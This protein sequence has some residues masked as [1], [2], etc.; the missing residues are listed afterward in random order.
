MERHLLKAEEIDTF[1]KEQPEW[2]FS[3][4]SLTRTYQFPDFVSAFAFMSAVATHC[5]C[6]NHHPDWSNVYGVVKV[7]LT[8][9]DRGGVTSLDTGLAQIMEDLANG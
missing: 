4:D 5:D 6:L 7:R 9:H 8:T 2:C 3:V 1:L